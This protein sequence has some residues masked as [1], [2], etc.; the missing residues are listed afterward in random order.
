MGWSSHLACCPEYATGKFSHMPLLTSALGLCDQ[1]E[2]FRNGDRAHV[3]LLLVVL[4]VWPEGFRSGLVS[5]L[6][7]CQCQEGYKVFAQ[8]TTRLVIWPE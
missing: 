8:S 5:P 3:M 7:K 2:G 4:S 6:E 1:P